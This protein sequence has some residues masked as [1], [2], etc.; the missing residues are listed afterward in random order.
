MKRIAKWTGIL[1]AVLLIVIVSVP[2]WIN[3]NQFKPT[4]ESSL[5][6]ALGRE[7]KLG[8]LGLSILSGEVTADDLSVSDDPHFGKPAFVRAKSLNVGVELL[9]FVLSRKLN[10][11][12]ITLDQPEIVLV[13]A[14]SGD[15]NFSTL[16]S[17]K[18]AAPRP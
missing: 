5:S 3:V 7:V 17:K 11:K 2:F 12:Q 16:G 13:Q 4:L 10:V 8:K 1:L 6:A 15:W 18:V 14:P 9:P